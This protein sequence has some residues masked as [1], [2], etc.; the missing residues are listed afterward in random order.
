MEKYRF[1]LIGA[2]ANGED[3]VCK[4][5]PENLGHMRLTRTMS[6]VVP[7]GW[8][9]EASAETIRLVKEDAEV[10]RQLFFRHGINQSLPVRLEALNTDTTAYNTILEA[11]VEWESFT[12]G[13]YFVEFAL[14]LNDIQKRWKDKADIEMFF[15]CPPN[16]MPI[17][18]PRMEMFSL[19]NLKG[20]NTLWGTT[21]TLMDNRS[22]IYSNNVSALT[23][24]RGGI[25]GQVLPMNNPT[26]CEILT[27]ASLPRTVSLDIKYSIFRLPEDTRPSLG[28]HL[29]IIQESFLIERNGN[30]T[31]LSHRPIFDLD[32]NPIEGKTYQRTINTALPSDSIPSDAK[33]IT[34]FTLFCGGTDPNTAMWNNRVEINISVGLFYAK[35]TNDFSALALT[36][37]NVFDQIARAL[38]TSVSIQ[39][40]ANFDPTHNL[41]LISGDMI[42]DV[43][44]S[45]G[46]FGFY[47]KPRDMLIDYC[48]IMCATFDFDRSGVLLIRPI[49]SIFQSSILNPPIDFNPACDIEYSYS[50]ESIFSG[51]EIGYDTP[52]LDYP[53][54][55]QNFAETLTYLLT[56]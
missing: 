41:R 44:N 4:Y 34:Q 26:L 9:V 39:S 23:M 48:K 7:I 32:N 37:R 5:L 22:R 1:I 3:Y 29:R 56:N 27:I 10:L 20:S 52:S 42:G 18:F 50:T 47:A 55:R 51:V 24:Q 38:G 6:M 30:I 53:T 19:I 46:K 16:A 14:Y 43:R 21:V 49:T 25:D 35:T 54:F 13:S 17:H 15:E 11:F 12:S 31:R 45:Q 36:Y 33:M 2:G 40:L 8:T 28:G